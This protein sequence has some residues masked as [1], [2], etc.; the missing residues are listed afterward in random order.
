MRIKRVLATVVL[1]IGIFIAIIGCGP[2]PDIS[3]TWTGV[4]VFDQGT[5]LAGLSY[6]LTLNLTQQGNNLS[7]YVGL[8]FGPMVGLMIP[9][10]SGTI[11][12]NSISITAI[13]TATVSDISI[14]TTINLDGD[15]SKTQMSGTGD[16]TYTF[17]GAG[18]GLQ[19]FTWQAQSS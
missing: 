2:T 16:Y 14:I 18:G 9:I 6:T 5:P 10:V 17:P 13:N 12:E 4:L 3:G 15:Y 7:G 1:V 11:T 8:G 19:T